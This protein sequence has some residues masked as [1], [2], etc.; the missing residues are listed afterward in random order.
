VTMNVV[1]END[2]LHDQQTWIA[3]PCFL[4]LVED[5]SGITMNTVTGT[6]SIKASSFT[7][8]DLVRPNSTR[9]FTTFDGIPFLDRRP[10]PSA[11]ESFSYRR[12]VIDNETGA[13]DISS[14]DKHPQISGN[15]QFIVQRESDPEEMDY[16]RNFFYHVKG[17]QKSFLI[18]TYFP[19]LTF[20][21]GQLPLSDAAS[22]FIVNEGQ[23]KTLLTDYDGFSRFE[24]EYSNKQRTQHKITASTQNEDG[25]MTISFT[26]GIPSGVVYRSP[27]KISYLM[28]VRAT[29]RIAWSHYANYSE[30][31]F[32][33]F[34]TD[35]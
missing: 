22:T 11:E 13:R 35:Q 15:R 14:R 17:A 33:I 24:L 21:S 28:R 23:V 32:G 34:T 10:V 19:D 2:I 1:A 8:P 7:D 3:I 26:P 25:T 16:W 4:C 18:S 29:D 30:L 27:I 31:S 6:L 12:E 5:G 20:L 9:T